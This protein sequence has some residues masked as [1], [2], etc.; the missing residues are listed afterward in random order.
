MYVIH[1]KLLQIV[2]MPF[3]GNLKYSKKKFKK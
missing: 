3:D 2:Y 1:R